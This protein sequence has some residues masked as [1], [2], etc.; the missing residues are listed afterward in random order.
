VRNVHTWLRVEEVADDYG[1]NVLQ[2]EEVVHHPVERR[3]L[4]DLLHL[5]SKDDGIGP[6]SVRATRK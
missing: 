1:G 5:Q 2:E 6:W 4:V 3:G